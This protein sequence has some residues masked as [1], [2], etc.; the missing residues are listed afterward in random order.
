MLHEIVACDDIFR[1]YLATFKVNRLTCS[2]T[3]KLLV[4][5]EI[6]LSALKCSKF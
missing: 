6:K 1:S 5:S 4:C 2:Q 3:L